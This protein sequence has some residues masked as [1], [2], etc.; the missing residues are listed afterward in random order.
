MKPMF[1]RFE[2]GRTEIALSA[3]NVDGETLAIVPVQK[4]IVFDSYATS[5]VS[6][7]F[8]VRPVSMG[9]IVTIPIIIGGIAAV[10]ITV[11]SDQGGIH[12]TVKPEDF[13]RL[14][15]H[16]SETLAIARDEEAAI[17]KENEDGDRD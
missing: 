8:A 17:N 13:A 5:S 12:M 11:S 1:T 3:D 7:G 16:A 4:R 2:I 9:S 14:V 10:A 6:K 15:E